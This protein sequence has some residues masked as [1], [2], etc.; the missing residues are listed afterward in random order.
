MELGL[1]GVSRDLDL[2]T[3]NKNALIGLVYE[4]MVMGPM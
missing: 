3:A 1:T 2:V 4:G